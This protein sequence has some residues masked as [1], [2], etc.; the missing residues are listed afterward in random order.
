MNAFLCGR[1]FT[2]V[3]PVFPCWFCADEKCDFCGEPFR[4][5]SSCSNCKPSKEPVRCGDS[6]FGLI[7]PP[8]SGK[9][10]YLACLHDQLMHSAP[11]WRVE[12]SDHAFW[13]LT[14]NY[15]Y[16]RSGVRPPKTDTDGFQ[17]FSMKTYWNHH[18]LDLLMWDMPGEWLFDL[19]EG[20]SEEQI[21]YNLAPHAYVKKSLYK[22]ISN[23]KSLIIAIPSFDLA[24]GPSS[25]SFDPSEDDRRY[26]QFFRRLLRPADRSLQ[27][28]IAMLVG[29]DAYGE[30]PDL[31]IPRAVK[32]F[33]QSYRAFPGTVKNACIDFEVVPVSNLGFGNSLTED[34]RGI[35]APPSPYNVLAPLRSTFVTHHP[36]PMPIDPRPA[37]TDQ[38]RT[39]APIVI[40]Q[41]QRVHSTETGREGNAASN[42]AVPVT[43]ERNERASR[44]F[45]SYRRQGGAETA[46]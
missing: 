42:T 32:H 28:V 13:Q 15:D 44:S 30:T 21:E 12:V 7:G 34:R 33:E 11:E 45:I 41:G 24:K 17:F 31:A 19:F 6:G 4:S 9:S 14:K 39:T 46:R 22:Q 20:E 1:C 25:C 5:R 40:P 3:D 37:M 35:S 26:G 36:S 23:C 43:T 38:G 2:P 29:V 16:M 18:W 27:K 10:V 8:N